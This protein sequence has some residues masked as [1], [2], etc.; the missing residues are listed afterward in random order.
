MDPAAQQTSS[1][2][3]KAHRSEPA[4]PTVAGAATVKTIAAL[5]AAFQAP[6]KP[7]LELA[8]MAPATRP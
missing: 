1:P 5:T 2:Y 4:A 7:V 3:A 6:A 8:K